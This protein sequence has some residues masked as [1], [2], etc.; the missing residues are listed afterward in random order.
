MH[1]L[2]FPVASLG[3]PGWG[4]QVTETV[5]GQALQPWLEERTEKSQLTGNTGNPVPSFSVFSEAPAPRQNHGNS[6]RTCPSSLQEPELQKGPFA[7]NRDFG[8]TWADPRY[9]CFLSL[10]THRLAMDMIKWQRC[11]E[12]TTEQSK[13]NPFSGPVIEKGDQRARKYLEGHR[14]GTVQEGVLC[15]VYEVLG[16]LQSNTCVDLIQIVDQRS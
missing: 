6:N 12:H 11:I 2:C 14:K 5:L 16:S 1:H 15:V 10:L 3:Q 4:H 7:L 9:F 13:N 8:P